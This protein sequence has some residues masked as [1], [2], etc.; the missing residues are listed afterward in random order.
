[1]IRKEEEAILINAEFVSS[2]CLILSLSAAQVGTSLMQI[3]FHEYNLVRKI[4][5][6]SNRKT[7]YSITA[8]SKKLSANMDFY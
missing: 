8:F 5:Q 4:S 3:F 2:I 7:A 6:L 1:M